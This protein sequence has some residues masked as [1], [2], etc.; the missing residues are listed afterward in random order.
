MTEFRIIHTD[1]FGR[2][3]PD[4]K[5]VEGLPFFYDQASAGCVC[6]AI[7]KVTP[8]NHDRY[9]RVVEMPYTLQGGFEP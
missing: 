6:E 1:N 4:E 9:Y 3:Y 2:D 8:E 5:F 7:N